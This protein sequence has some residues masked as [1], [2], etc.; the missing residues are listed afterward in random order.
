MCKGLAVVAERIEGIWQIYAKEGIISHDILLHEL[1]EDLRDG[2]APHIKF[3]VYFPMIINDDIQQDVA[4]KYYP[5]GWVENKFGKWCACPE[6]ISAVAQYLNENRDLI[7]FTPKML[8]HASL[9]YAS[10][11]DASLNR[12]SLDHAS[13]NRASLND[14][15]LNGASLDHAWLDGASLNHASLNHASLNRASLNGA[16]LDGASLNHA[17][18][19]GAS[20]NYASLSGASLNGASLSGA[21]LNYAS[22]NDASLNGASLD[23]S[24]LIKFWTEIKLAVF[25]KMYVDLELKTRAEIEESIKEIK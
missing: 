20:L 7:N 22:L 23:R 5:E 9:N 10:L 19:N 11:N 17:S 16:S 2:I 21:S 25:E 12:A 18:L 3:E 4:E 1:R 15:S 24:T 13:L 8:H 6:S 14:A